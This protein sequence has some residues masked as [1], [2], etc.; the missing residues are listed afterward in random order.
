[1][2]RELMAL[3]VG[4]CLPIC[5]ELPKR[6]MPVTTTER[7]EF[8]TGGAIR[9]EG[10]VGELNIEGWDRPD[11]EITVTRSTYRT[12]S[13]QEQEQAKLQLDAI[14]VTTER[15]GADLIIQTVFPK[16]RL[17][18]RLAPRRPD[19]RMDYRIRAPRQAKLVIRHGSGDVVIY[20][21]AGDIDA[22]AGT[23]DILVQLPDPGQY[24][25]DAQ[26]KA[27]G[28]YSDFA[29]NR[30]A[31]HWVGERFYRDGAAPATARICAWA[32]AASRSRR[33][34]LESPWR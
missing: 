13:T 12:D 17:L 5:A 3:A 7:V 14:H 24:A 28:V 19:V 29:G 27:G 23:G 18:A 1:M 6:P 25:F 10:S 11:V 2:L 4:V 30:Q 9:V 32:S 31:A 16:R 26:C 8:A 15:K 21:M 33:W 34:P 22:S 20:D